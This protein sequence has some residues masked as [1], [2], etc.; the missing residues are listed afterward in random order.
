MSEFWAEAW[1]YLAGGGF[2]AAVVAVF[3]F[4]ASGRKQDAAE[5]VRLTTR[6]LS[7]ETKHDDCI[8]LSGIQQ[9]KIAMLEDKVADLKAEVK[10]LREWR[11]EIAGQAQ[12]I[13]AT[14]A[15]DKLSKG[16]A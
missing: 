13:V 3:R 12:S 1:K 11:H 8:E 2:V 5:F 10:S 7:L 9:G 6:I 4:I 16:G 14:A 15:A